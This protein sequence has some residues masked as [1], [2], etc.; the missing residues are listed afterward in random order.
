MKVLVLACL[1]ALAL[2][3][4]KEEVIISTETVENLSS[5]EESIPNINKRPEQSGDEK[6]PGRKD[7][8][9]DNIHPFM[10]PQ[11]LFYP[12]PQPIPNTV[13]PQNVLPLAQPSVVLPILQPHVMEAPNAKET[14]VPKRNVMPVL[15]SPV[16]PFLER[17]IPSVTDLKIPQIPL[18]LVQPMM[19]QVH[20]P[21]AQI[22]VF[23]SQS[24]LSLPQPKAQLLSQQEM[25]YPQRNMLAQ[26]PLL[27]PA[28]EPLLVPTQ[29]FY[30]VTQPIAPVY[31]LQ[32]VSPN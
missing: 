32:Q 25:T 20:Q 30:P 1:V 18:P 17:Q 24:L 14:I 21:L 4:E 10:Q 3:G 7:E 26:E 27:V 22:P 29:Q 2:A 13:L 8:R 9:Q 11:P 5:S 16:V 6:Q 19:Q 15:N 28:Q 23:P 31:N 12:Y